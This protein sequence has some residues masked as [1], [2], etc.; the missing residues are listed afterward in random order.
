MK[1]RQ[2]IK[3]YF[4]FLLLS[5][6]FLH[7]GSCD[8][9]DPFEEEENDTD[10]PKKYTYVDLGLSVKWATFNVGANAPEE[11]GDYFAWGE[12]LPNRHYSWDFYTWGNSHYSLIKY[13]NDRQYGYNGFMDNKTILDIEDDAA[14]AN[15]GDEWRIPTMEEQEELLNECVWKW[16]TL[17][18]VYG[19]NITGPNGN[20]LFLPAAGIMIGSTLG[21]AGEQGYYWANSCLTSFPSYAWMLHFNSNYVLVDYYQRFYGRTIRPVCP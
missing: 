16:T 8:V 20:S 17:N 3:D 19:Y 9:Y 4:Y 6:L 10:I 18:G 13:C 5:C 2:Y 7:L 14:H 21:N 12:V 11:Y 1:L 15:W